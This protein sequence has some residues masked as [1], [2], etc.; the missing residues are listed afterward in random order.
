M[1]SS[2]RLIGLI[3]ASAGLLMAS[4]TFVGH[5]FIADAKAQG[6]SAPEDENALV[7]RGLA[8]NAAQQPGSPN[9]RQLNIFL[10]D[11][12]RK[13]CGAVGLLDQ[14]ALLAARDRFAN[15]ALVLAAANGHGDLAA[16]FLDEGATLNPRSSAASALTFSMIGI[17]PS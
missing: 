11:A 17:P 5:I 15:T 7:C 3:A 12:A 6:A 8:Q 10:F 1:R 16:Y 14:G 2:F 4:P 13:G 9:S